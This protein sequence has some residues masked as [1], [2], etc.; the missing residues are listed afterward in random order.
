[1]N[2]S[3][4]LTAA[5]LNSPDVL[6]RLRRKEGFSL[7]PK[8][9]PKLYLQ[10]NSSEGSVS[11]QAVWGGDASLGAAPQLLQPRSRPPRTSPSPG[12]ERSS[13]H[14]ETEG[15]PGRG[16]SLYLSGEGME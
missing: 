1:M 14:P 8:E 3:N 10:D 7:S 16:W 5:K 13:I 2:R 6:Y 11:L 12:R 4:F 15:S 9:E